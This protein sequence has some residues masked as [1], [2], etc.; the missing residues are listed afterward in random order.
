VP[1]VERLAL[2]GGPSGS[3][4]AFF[5]ARGGSLCFP[6]LLTQSFQFAK[7]SKQIGRCVADGGKSFLTRNHLNH[8]TL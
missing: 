8:L 4:C 6:D 7:L 2:V 3:K 5:P 1:K